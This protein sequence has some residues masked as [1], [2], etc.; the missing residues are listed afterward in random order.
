MCLCYD[1]F[2][3]RILAFCGRDWRDPK[4]GDPER[5]MH[6]VLRRMAAQGHYVVWVCPIYRTGLL[7]GRRPDSL[8]MVDG[9]QVAR[10]GARFLYRTMAG[11]FLSRLRERTQ[12]TAPF[13]VILDC[14]TRRPLNL[15]DKTDTP[16]VPVVFGLSPRLRA[17]TQPPGPVIAA[18]RE[19]REALLRS[20]LPEKFIVTASFG[21]EDHSIGP[22]CAG[23]LPAGDRSR[24]AADVAGA[25]RR[26]LAGSRWRTKLAAPS[27]EIA[28]TWDDT[29]GLV[30]A[31]IENLELP[32]TAQ[33]QRRQLMPVP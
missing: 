5:Y 3:K 18:S 23:G 19:A 1:I 14:V 12:T 21:T 13:D 16:I 10:L 2:M 32:A 31:T 15:A 6:E 29:A 20:G 33:P 22:G 28:P 30:L 25:I 11:M 9:I 17:D 24:P 26:L 8:E 27:L 4:A 7:R